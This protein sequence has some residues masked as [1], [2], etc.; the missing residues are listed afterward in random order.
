MKV[1]S[2]TR[3]CIAHRLTR[4]FTRTRAN[5]QVYAFKNEG[6]ETGN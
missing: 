2:E 6:G 1:Y 3:P 4:M 5:A